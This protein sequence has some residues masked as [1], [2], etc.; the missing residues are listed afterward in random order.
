[1][2]VWGWWHVLDFLSNLQRLSFRYIGLHVSFQVV[3][4]LWTC[5]G[6]AAKTWWQWESWGMLKSRVVVRIRWMHPE[7]LGWWM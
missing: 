6:G 5:G 3:Q 7:S 2:K 1:M 4:D